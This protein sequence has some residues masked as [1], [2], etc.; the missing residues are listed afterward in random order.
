MYGL[1]RAGTGVRSG[2]VES[3]GE[4]VPVLSGQGLSG[5]GLSS[6]VWAGPEKRVKTRVRTKPG[7]IRTWIASPYLYTGAEHRASHRQ[8]FQECIWEKTP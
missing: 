1:Y 4:K 5:K 3:G 2:L 6:E 8:S 7:V